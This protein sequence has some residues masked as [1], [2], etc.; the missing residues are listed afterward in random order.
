MNILGHSNKKLVD[1]LIKQGK[2]LWHTSNLYRIKNQ[3]KLAR[4]LVENTFADKVFFTN[5]GTES[6]ECAVKMARIYFSKLGQKRHEILSFDGCFHGRSLGAI[7]TSN[8]KKMKD[9]VH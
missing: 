9:L 1:V 7:S 2:N 5:S 6:I 8:S 3:E 4:L